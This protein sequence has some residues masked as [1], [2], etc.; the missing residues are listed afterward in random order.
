[1]R[2][3]E[4]EGYKFELLAKPFIRRA[5]GEAKAALVDHQHNLVDLI[6]GDLIPT[7]MAGLPRFAGDDALDDF[8]HPNPTLAVTTPRVTVS[9]LLATDCAPISSCGIVRALP[10]QAQCK[11][12][13][14]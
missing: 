7:L 10:C 11:L 13:G 1:M 3:A 14:T 9:T 8:L 6:T 12:G 2:Q 5:G 4:A